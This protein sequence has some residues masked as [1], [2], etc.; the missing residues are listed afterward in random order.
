MDAKPDQEEMEQAIDQ[1]LSCLQQTEGIGFWGL[2]NLMS[3][4][5]TPAK[6]MGSSLSVATAMEAGFL[7]DPDNDLAGM[8]T[9]SELRLYRHA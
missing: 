9:P 4:L 2:D 5:P 1:F 6:R 7:P 8:L 3:K